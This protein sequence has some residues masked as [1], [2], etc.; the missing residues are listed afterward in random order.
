MLPDIENKVLDAA[1]NG[2]D[3]ITYKEIAKQENHLSAVFKEEFEKIILDCDISITN[4]YPKISWD[5]ADLRWIK[6]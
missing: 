6:S 1:K 2:H 4:G 3:N 5:G